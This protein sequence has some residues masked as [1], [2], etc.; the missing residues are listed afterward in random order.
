MAPALMVWVAV[1]V[2]VIGKSSIRSSD[3]SLAI[4]SVAGVWRTLITLGELLQLDGVAGREGVV[5]SG[6]GAG[7]LGASCCAIY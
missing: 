4:A 1:W 6:G 2:S 3:A 5:F 7:S